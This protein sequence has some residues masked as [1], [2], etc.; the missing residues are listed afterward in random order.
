MP[1]GEYGTRAGGC[2]VTGGYVYRGFAQPALSGAY[3]FADYC[4]G[5]FWSL[6][7]DGAGKWIQSELTNTGVQVSSF[8]EDEAGELYVTGHGDG[9]LY[10]VVA[11]A[12]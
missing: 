2:A 3:L 6:H 8:A 1:I 12:R 10:R 7:R 5:R 4:C 11:A 9:R